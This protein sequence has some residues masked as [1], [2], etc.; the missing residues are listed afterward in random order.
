MTVSASLS[1][2]RIWRLAWPILI[3]HSTGP[4][5]GLVDTAV[6]GHLPAAHYLGGVAVGGMII[7]FILWLCGFLRMSTTALTAQARGG[8][9][10]LAEGRQLIQALLVAMGL[11][12]VLVVTAPL[13]L[14]LA[15][16]LAGGSEAVL[17]VAR[18][19]VAIRLW[20]LPPA[21]VNLVLLGYLLGRQQSRHVLYLTV[22]QHL[23]N[24]VLDVLFVPVMGWG[25]AGVAWT[26]L[27]R[28]HRRHPS[29]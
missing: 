14:E 10:R 7:T 8:A 3:A 17:A 23:F 20:S 11:A 25:V 13:W 15:L 1:H 26:S 19:Y 28:Q 6:I 5:L 29:P 16:A 4:L 21:L 22:S 9:D 24:L 2:G 27:P 12:L 18:D